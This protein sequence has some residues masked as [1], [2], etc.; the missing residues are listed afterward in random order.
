MLH[1]IKQILHTQRTTRV[2]CMCAMFAWLLLRGTSELALT[3]KHRTADCAA[4]MY[5]TTKT[6]IYT[7]TDVLLCTNAHAYVSKMSVAD[8]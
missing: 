5:I 2:S 1:T 7:H 3:P 6:H 4:H 8:V